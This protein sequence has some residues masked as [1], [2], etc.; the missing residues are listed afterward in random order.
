MDAF[1]AFVASI[2]YRRKNGELVDHQLQK[3]L[4]HAAREA[5]S[6]RRLFVVDVGAQSLA[7]EEHIYQPLLSSGVLCDIVGFDPLAHRLRERANKESNARLSLLPFAI[8]DGKSHTL[9]I[10]NDDATS[11][12]YSLNPAAPQ[13]LEGLDDLHTVRRETV[14]TRRLD[15]VLP[16]RPVDFL[17]LDIQGFELRALEHATETLFRTAVVHCETE[18]YPLYL[19]QPLFPDIHRY[20]TARGFDFID[21]VKATRFAPAVPSGSKGPE[22]LVFGDAVFF[23]KPKANEHELLLVQAL[24]AMLVYKKTALAESLLL[25]YDP[26]YASDFAFQATR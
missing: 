20:L 11:S 24:I 9:H 17:K 14:N 8:G 15:D 23:R 13:A 12:L 21:L 3:S 4:L 7:W 18:F 5:F 19:G 22:R 25:R 16:N 10:N 26:N 6:Q 1:H 2:E